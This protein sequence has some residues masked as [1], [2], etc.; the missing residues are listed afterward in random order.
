[1]PASNKTEGNLCHLNFC[2]K[3]RIPKLLCYSGNEL[4]PLNVQSTFLTTLNVQFEE[5]L[6]QTGN[7]NNRDDQFGDMVLIVR[8]S[9]L[10]NE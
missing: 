2:L 7:K 9:G 3:S 8:F 4:L 5:I 6:K 10:N 1:M